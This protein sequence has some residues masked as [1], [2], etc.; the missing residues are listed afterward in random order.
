MN[1]PNKLTMVRIILIPIIM[2][3]YGV[4]NSLRVSQVF[5]NLSTANFI[6]LI[7]F[8]VGAISDFLDG[9][10]ARSRNLITDLGKFLDPLADKL[11][12]TTL[13]IILLNQ[14]MLNQQLAVQYDLT[15]PSLVEWWMVIIVIAREFVVT[16]VRLIAAGKKRVIAA[17]WYGK[18]KTTTQF[19]TILVILFNG[20]VVRTSSGYV[21]VETWV[22]Y[23]D[24]VL[25]FIM[26]AAT[27]FSGADYVIKN[28][29][30]FKDDFGK[31][32]QKK[33]KGNKPELVPVQ[34]GTPVQP[35]TPVQPSIPSKP[36][37]PVQPASGNQ[38]VINPSDGK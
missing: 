23:F 30:I 11:L 16:G 31:K 28:K 29:D 12:V 9:K 38:T 32:N 33:N 10:I 26:I 13:L 18:I 37:T 27:I 4:S 22:A 7:L 17:S 3:V 20:S 1:L 8:F 5:G 14:N 6:I 2:I 24:K 36:N 21:G 19:I 35:D 15:V 25:L 34:P